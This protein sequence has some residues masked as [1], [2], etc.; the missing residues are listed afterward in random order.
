MYRLNNSFSLIENFGLKQKLSNIHDL[1]ETHLK[2]L[3]IYRPN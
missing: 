1:D 3:I 2:Q